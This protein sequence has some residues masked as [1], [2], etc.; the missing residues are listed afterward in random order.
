MS[1]RQQAFVSK[2]SINF[3]AHYYTTP[4]VNH[5]AGGAAFL[6]PL[7]TLHLSSVRW[8]GCQAFCHLWAVRPN[9]LVSC[10]FQPCCKLRQFEWLPLTWACDVI[11]SVCLTKLRAN[12]WIHMVAV[13]EGGGGW[14]I[15]TKI[16]SGETLRKELRRWPECDGL[17]IVNYVG[18]AH[19]QVILRRNKVFSSQVC[20]LVKLPTVWSLASSVFDL[21]SVPFMV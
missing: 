5:Q 10:I 19:H 1:K 15:K 4:V 9:I 6:S 16:L 20:W 8:Q 3:C 11:H 17:L 13:G 7:H 18:N 14:K 21:S 2:S 12:F